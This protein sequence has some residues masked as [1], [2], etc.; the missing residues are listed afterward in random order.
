MILALFR[1]A[2]DGI[3]REEALLSSG[4]PALLLWQAE[5]TALVVPPGWTRR[6]GFPA[7]QE[8]CAQAGWPLIARS[9]GG[10][11]VPQW[12][13]TINLALVVPAQP[14][15]TIQDGYRLICGA[16]AEALAR[17][18]VATDA[19]AV[20]GSFCDGDWNV[21]AGGRKLGGTAQRW[22]A[23]ASG[24]VA[25]VHA[26]LLLKPPPAS[27]WTALDHAQRAP[28]L[29]GPIRPEA[30][31]AL[32]ELLPGGMRIGSVF[33]ALARAAEDRLAALA[34]KRRRAA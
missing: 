30:H 6:E 17:F 33:G 25:L 8:R 5:T 9:S 4:R 31:V 18:E 19:G 23:C 24:R 13:G 32:S 34:P 12:P 15:F 22:R 26:A 20:E 1:T 10:G 27:F 21:T 11:G 16:I 7:A 3:A 29:A 14:G 28:G 2:A